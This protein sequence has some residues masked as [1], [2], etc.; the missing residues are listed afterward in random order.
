MKRELSVVD[1]ETKP[2]GKRAY[3]NYPPEPV[4]VAILKGG[5]EEYL[6]WGHLS[7]NN[8]TKENA[9]RRLKSIW[10]SDT[11]VFHN[12]S[13][14][15]EVGN[16]WLGLSYLP[17]DR[18]EDTLFLAYLNDPRERELGLKPLADSYLNMPPDEQT[19]LRDWIIANI[20]EAKRAKSR[21]GEYLWMAPGSLVGRYAK[22]DVRR[23]YKLF[24]LWHKSV[25]VTR[26]MGE[27]YEREKKLVPVLIDMEQRGI[28]VAV[29][30]LKRD[31]KEWEAQ[32]DMFRNKAMSRLHLSP[33]ARKEFNLGSGEQLADALDEA[34]LVSD[35]V[36]TEKG[37]RSTARDSLIASCNDKKFVEYYN[38][39]S[40]FNHTL[41]NFVYP[42]IEDGTASGGFLHTKFNQ[43]R[44]SDEFGRRT[45]GTRTGRLSSE[46]PN[47]QNVT[48]TPSDKTHP[49]LR[50]YLV[51]YQG[52][53]FI[54]RDYSQQELRILAHFEDGDLLSAYLASPR[55][56]IHAYVGDL[57][58]E[59]LGVTYDR[60]DIKTT[61]FGIIYGMGIG[62][63]AERAGKTYEE[64][65]SL[66][67]AV[68]RAIP[69]I[70]TLSDELR[71]MAKE[72]L[73]LRTWGGRLYYC[74]EPKM[75]K[76]QMRSFEYK[77]LNVLIQGSAADCTKQAMINVWE[78]CDSHIV[79]QVHDE[80]LNC[81]PKGQEKKEMARMREAM[82][83]VKFDVPMLSDGKVGSYSWGS[84][85]DY[86]EAA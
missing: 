50:N 78:N 53:V 66:K 11:V 46:D 34:G 52:G 84:M 54:R 67:N 61:N 79:L 16:A 41:N 32:R 1:F 83:S 23:T 69:G 63:L 10:E 14:D 68:L 28:P 55:M 33:A 29:S 85:T 5:K 40:V 13:F 6:A 65:K 37:N 27:A 56:D 39:W 24:K 19:A 3:G 59:L 20:P 42:W 2:I 71:D 21:W 76:G 58:R 38:E 36:L 30:R 72:N 47:L 81:C 75:V 12:G 45:G 15:M 43:V 49:W 22:G 62:T 31:V 80:L 60:N 86:K 26:S 35:W 82:E 51:P 77:M 70:K 73:P 25:T 44:N 9:R 4:G 64:A 7:E 18:F 8:T 74:E 48:R 17:H 57:I